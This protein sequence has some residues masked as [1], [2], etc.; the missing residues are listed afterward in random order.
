M[1]VSIMNKKEGKF[2]QA[3][4]NSDFPRAVPRNGTY[5]AHRC[6]TSVFGMGTGVS[7]GTWP[8]EQDGETKQ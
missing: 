1:Q 8:L 2:C 5:W 7:S 4:R 3:Q 6:L